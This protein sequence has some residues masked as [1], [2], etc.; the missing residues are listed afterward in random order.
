MGTI[1]LVGLGPGD[2]ALLTREAWSL[3][4]QTATLSTPVPDHPALVPL[5]PHRVCPLRHSSP[6]AGAAWL[7]EQA[8]RSAPGEQ[9]VCALPGHPGDD[10]LFAALQFQGAVGPQ[11]PP[12]LRLVPGISLID[13]FCT[14]LGVGRHHQ[15]MQVIGVEHL[16]PPPPVI[17]PEE[18]AWCELQDVGSY[19]PPLL[20]YPLN[21]VRPALIWLRTGDENG[22]RDGDRVEEHRAPTLDRV[23]AALLLRYPPAHP[24]RLVRLNQRGEAESTWNVA[25]SAL[26]GEAP[27]PG[28]RSALY[29][30]PL[31]LL[32]NRRDPDGLAWVVARLLG[33]GGCPW[34][35]EQTF[36]SLRSG[37]LEETCE[38]LEALD[39]GDMAMLVE[40]L[41]DVLLQVVLLSEM[42]RQ[43]SSFCL[44][45]VVF[46]VTEKLI[47]R[48]PHVF[49]RL[50]VQSTDEVLSNW[51]QIKAEE[52]AEKGRQR[53]SALDGV[54]PALPALAAAQKLV[55]KSSRAGF[56]WETMEE[57]WGK[58]QEELDELIQAYQAWKGEASPSPLH[59]RQLAEELGDVLFTIVNLARWLHLDAEAALRETNA[60]FRRRFAA[61]E[62][63]A[64]RR[65]SD[66]PSLSMAGK[67]ALWNEAKQG[68]GT[69]DA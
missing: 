31:P 28:L 14:A 21:P 18:P 65:G 3:L 13:C 42:A 37:L 25:L 69:G 58:F 55:K 62:A 63:L 54:P 44:E 24:L 45:D 49:G 17:D 53:T 27:G 6:Q 23:R 34:D 12:P 4:E 35:R 66:L 29:V 46:Q 20:P 32:A 36:R 9:V 68:I 51:E 57:V 47:R 30:E 15:G 16:E 33:P 41:G 19:I 56:D 11:E 8:A 39:H 2:P 60:K 26:G 43:S 5:P 52:L 40:E 50:E 48:H 61:M 10:A 22:G 67:I 1:I 38:V 59:H 64:R 7:R